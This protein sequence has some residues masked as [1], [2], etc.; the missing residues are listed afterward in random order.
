METMQAAIVT[1]AL[2]SPQWLYITQ[3]VYERTKG[4]NY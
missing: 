1:Q 2:E 4:D 3:Q